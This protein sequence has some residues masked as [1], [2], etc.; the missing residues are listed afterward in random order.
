MSE[1]RETSIEF[2]P[3]DEKPAESPENKKQIKKLRIK[4]IKEF[5]EPTQN[6]IMKTDR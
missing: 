3:G 1:K 6:S 4:Q 5:K 2:P